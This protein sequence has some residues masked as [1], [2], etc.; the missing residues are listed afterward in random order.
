MNANRIKKWLVATLILT[1]MLAGT[2]SD[3]ASAKGGGY[4]FQIDGNAN[5][6]GW[7]SWVSKL[8]PSGA[9]IHWNHQSGSWQGG[10]KQAV[11]NATA[12]WSNP[13]HVEKDQLKIQ[14]PD[15]PDPTPVPNPTPV[16]TGTPVPPVYVK[17]DKD[18]TKIVAPKRATYYPSGSGGLTITWLGTLEKV[19]ICTKGMHCIPLEPPA[20]WVNK[21]NHHIGWLYLGFVLEPGT[22]TIYGHGPDGSTGNDAN[23]VVRV[24]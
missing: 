10:Q 18:V 9:S 14:R 5:C 3:S 23:I 6:Q 20:V 2:M 8:S 19:R 17:S 12:K 4:I 11:V 21:D 16:P 7:D 13:T 15:C 24:K 1:V 22:Y